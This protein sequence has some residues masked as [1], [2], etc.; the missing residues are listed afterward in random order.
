VK[1]TRQQSLTI[2][3]DMTLDKN[4]AICVIYLSNGKELCVLAVVLNYVPDQEI[5]AT[6]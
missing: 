6:E 4:D 2:P 1:T 5:H 3:S